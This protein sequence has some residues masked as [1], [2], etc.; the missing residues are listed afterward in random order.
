M[1]KR[2]SDDQFSEAEA[3]KRRD[4]II[5]RMIATPPVHNAALKSKASRARKATEKPA[6][7]GV[8]PSK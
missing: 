2:S 5:R 4:A 6:K 1:V 8:A 3:A 7:P